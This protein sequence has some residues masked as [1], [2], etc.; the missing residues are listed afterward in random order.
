MQIQAA[1]VSR[2]EAEHLGKQLHPR[3]EARALGKD[4]TVA[5]C[6]EER[7]GCCVPGSRAEPDLLGV[8]RYQGSSPQC[9][10]LGCQ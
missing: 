9:Y 3:A 5:H 7:L 6:M 8:R 10:P 4:V 1:A 2:V